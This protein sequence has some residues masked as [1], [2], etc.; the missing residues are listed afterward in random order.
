MKLHWPTCYRSMDSGR[1]MQSA[2]RNSHAVKW[3]SSR[4]H[5]N[6]SK[7]P[8]RFHRHSRW[9]YIQQQ[10]FSSSSNDCW[11]TK[12]SVVEPGSCLIA[13]RLKKKDKKKVCQTYNDNF[14]FHRRAC[15]SFL[16]DWTVSFMPW[17]T[18]ALKKVCPRN[19]RAISVWLAIARSQGQKD[20]GRRK[21]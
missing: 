17:R 8:G 20:N 4:T 18:A 10:S 19:L 16:Y 15:R 12:N 3:V 11:K 2:G 21:R 14:Q 7:Q 13:N 9:L 1:R 6:V 5:L